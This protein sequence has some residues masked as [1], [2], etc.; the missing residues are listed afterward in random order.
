MGTLLTL[1]ERMLDPRPNLSWLN[2]REPAGDGT[3]ARSRVRPRHILSN[4][5][6]LVGSLIVLALFLIVLVGPLLAPENPYL[7]GQRTVTYEDGKLTAPPFPPSAEYPLGTNQ[8]GKDLLSLLLYGARNTLVA[9][10]FIAMTRMLLGLGLGAAAGWHEGQ[11][12]DRLV[13]GGI[14]LTTALPI[15]LSSMILIY[16]LDIRRGLVVFIIALSIVGWAEVAQYI[17]T[18]FILLRQRPFMEGARAVGLPGLGIAVR[19]VLPNIL[20]HLLVI[21]LLE[22]SAVLL[23]LGELGFIG[24]YIGGG[25]VTTNFDDSQY[26]I[27]DIPE[28]GVML[29]DA[30]RWVQSKPWMVLYPALAFFIAVLGFNALAEGLPRLIEQAPISTAFLLRKRMLLVIAAITAATIYTVNNVGPAPTFARLANQFQ[31][32]SATHHIQTLTQL[33]D[34]SSGQPANRAAAEYIAAQFEAYGLQPAGREGTY[35]QRSHTFLIRP[36]AQPALALVDENDQIQ[37]S[38]RHQQDF[39]FVIDGHG[40]SGQARAPLAFVGFRTKTLPWEAYR[41][42]DLQGRIVLLLADN[43]P[44]DF[45]TEALIRRAAGVL[46]VTGDGPYDVRSQIQLARANSNYLR[47]PTLPIL[48]IRPAVADILLAPAGVDLAALRRQ[49]VDWPT[50]REEPW[51]LHEFESRVQISVALSE[52]AEVELVNVLGYIPGGD[53]ALNDQLVIL[54]AHYDTLPGEPDGTRY[55][56]ANDNGSGLAVLLEVA[57]LWQE[58]GLTPRRGVLFAAWAGGALDQAAA[59][60]FFG[61]YLGGV[62]LLHPAAIFQLDNLGAGGDYLRLDTN[63]PRLDAL[64]A[65]SAAQMGLSLRRGGGSYHPYQEFLKSQTDS[66]LISWDQAQMPPDRDLVERIDPE[67]LSRAGE[68]VILAAT[69]AVRL[70][71]Y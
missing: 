8:W 19:H 43:A 3:R 4:F 61:G 24:V 44:P 70:P 15:L 14:G 63:D 66:V 59:G 12:I 37:H 42:L 55:A 41:G 36:L 10:T 23:L 48:R 58:Q 32:E 9:C 60:E 33:G 68:T 2:R 52:P 39:G 54:S 18:E 20:P 57:R 56:G 5:P 16:A 31:A 29:A 51:L 26:T 7:A 21:T 67:K 71:D 28:W 65:Q 27:P 64:V 22:M 17:R 30:R 35:L 38:F 13:M 11:L 25:T 6:L 62:S 50:A 47:R 53:I 46:W 40:G 69:N 49:L 34:R 1:V 45:P